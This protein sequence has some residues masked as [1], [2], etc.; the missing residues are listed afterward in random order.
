MYIFYLKLPALAR[1]VGPFKLEQNL[2]DLDRGGA[3]VVT[4]NKQDGSTTLALCTLCITAEYNL[5][6]KMEYMIDEH[7]TFEK[8]VLWFY[9]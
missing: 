7:H 8:P 2:S 9:A 3:Q 6:D 5:A 4:S 1:C